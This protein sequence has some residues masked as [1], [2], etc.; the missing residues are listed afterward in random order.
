MQ[1]ENPIYQNPCNS[2]LKNSDFRISMNYR[3]QWKSVT[4]S[5]NT[6]SLSCD[7]KLNTNNR[8]GIG[9]IIINDD[10]GDG[11]LK[12]LEI[13][14]NLNYTLYKPINERYIITIGIDIGLNI[15]NLISKIINLKANIMG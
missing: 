6:F 8:I 3:N 14:G 11:K 7:K 5:F 12:T 9:A 15:E 1:F 4:K 13:R 10:A 2:G